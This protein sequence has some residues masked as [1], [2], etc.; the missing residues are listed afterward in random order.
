[1]S[2]PQPEISDRE[3]RPDDGAADRARGR[4]PRA[5]QRPTAPPSGSAAS[6]W[7]AS[8][9][10]RTPSR[11]SRSTTRTP[12]TSSAS[13][14]CGCARGLNPG[15]PVRVR[16]RAQGRRRGRLAAVRARQVRA[17]LDPRRRRA[18]R[19]HHGQFARRS[20][21]SRWCSDRPPAALLEVRG[22]VYM[23]NSEL[24]RLNEL[25]TAAGRAPVRQS[26]QLDSRLAQAARLQALRR[27]AG[28]G[29]S[30]TAWASPQG[31][32]R[33][34][35]FRDHPVD[36]ALGHPRQPPHQLLRLDRASDRARPA[37]ERPAE[38][39]RFPDRRPGG[40]GRRSRSARAARR[41]GARARGGRSPSSTRPSRRS[42]KLSGH[43]AFRSGKTG[44]ITPVAELEPVAAGRHD[45]QAG[46]PAQ[47]RRARA[48]GHPGRRHGRDPEGRR[49]HPAGRAGRDRR[50]RRHRD[51]RSTF[52]RP[53]RAAARR[54]NAPGDEVDFH[55]T[56]PPSR[57]PDQLKEWLR[58]YAHR[59]AHG[60]R[61][62]GRKAR[63]TSSSTRSWSRASPIS[64]DWMRPRSPSWS[65]WARNRPTTWCRASRP[66]STERST[67]CSR[68]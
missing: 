3:Y 32:E 12:T 67:G 16:R 63:S 42:R 1:M 37:L 65:G 15:E 41:R 24:V 9:R 6:R 5:G 39:A 29:S 38:H 57:C 50:T 60:Y 64:T 68:D 61:R 51:A 14:T 49:D 54:S 13:G 58:W 62:P 28:C 11:C 53:A 33:I 20:A 56:N 40:Q 47:R 36:E 19:R 27:S 23:T 52:P 48:Q 35:V 59:D 34:V 66:A 8:R 30:R 26:A 45:R 7:R 22:E 21:R 25:R 10:S 2:R 31:I 46:Q 4:A 43:H 55:C 44:K 18:R 17:G